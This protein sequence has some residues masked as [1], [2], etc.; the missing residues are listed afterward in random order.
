MRLLIVSRKPITEAGE[1]QHDARPLE[2]IAAL[3]ASDLGGEPSK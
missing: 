2:L 1:R 3:P